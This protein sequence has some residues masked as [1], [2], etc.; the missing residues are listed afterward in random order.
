MLSHSLSTAKINEQT[1]TTLDVPSADAAGVFQ[2]RGYTLTSQTRLPMALG[3]VK[4][5]GATDYVA[6]AARASGDTRRCSSSKA[7]ELLE[8]R[9]ASD[10]GVDRLARAGHGARRASHRGVA[11][12]LI[13]LDG[14]DA[15]GD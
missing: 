11:R 3:R 7:W 1:L 6:A 4:V 15:P 10:R 8:R 14:R 13:A 2:K 5:T 9:G 12:R